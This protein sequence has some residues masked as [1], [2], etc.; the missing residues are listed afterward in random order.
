MPNADDLPSGGRPSVDGPS[1]KSLLSSAQVIERTRDQRLVMVGASELLY[2]MRYVNPLPIVYFNKPTL[3]VY[4]RPGESEE[5]AM[6]RVVLST[7]LRWPRTCSS[8]EP[9]IC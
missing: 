9:P 4:G 5:E 1:A 3:K 2:L 6:M 7:D 8:S